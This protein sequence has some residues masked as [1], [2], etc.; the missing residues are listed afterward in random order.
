LNDID[1]DTSPSLQR[2]EGLNTY[3][4]VP[5]SHNP[6]TNVSSTDLTCNVNGL[7]GTNVATVS[8]P[9]ATIV[10]VHHVY[11]IGLQASLTV[12]QQQMTFEWHQDSQRTGEPA[13]SLGHKG[14]VQV[15]I[16]KAPSTAAS[17]DGQ[18]SVWTKIYSSGLI[19]PLTQLWASEVVNATNGI[20]LYPVEISHTVLLITAFKGRHSVVIPP[21]LPAGQYLL[22][23]EIVS[24]TVLCEHAFIDGSF[25]SPSTL[26]R[27]TLALNSLLVKRVIYTS[28]HVTDSLFRQAASKLR[29][30]VEAAPAHR[31]SLSREDTNQL[32]LASRRVP[33]VAV[34]NSLLTIVFRFPLSGQYL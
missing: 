19:V 29:S 14:P 6:V 24:S 3:I 25:R 27:H 32:I 26:Q 17:F 12:L 28:N 10:R 33:F 31:Q 7:S 34:L 20:S 1:A 4:R 13:I 15:Y 23:A 11:I 30:R 16:A 18:G 9:P 5:P 22:R 2:D 8:I 21:S